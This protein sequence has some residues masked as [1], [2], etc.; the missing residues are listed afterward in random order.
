LQ[1]FTLH[2][3]VYTLANSTSAALLG[4]VS[5][6]YVGS[7]AS[8]ASWSGIRNY[9]LTSPSTHTGISNLTPGNYVFGLMASAGN[10]NSIHQQI[11]GATGTGALAGVGYVIPGVNQQSTHTSQGPVFIG[12]GSTTVNAMPANVVRSELVGQGGGASSPLQPWMVLRS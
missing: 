5:E 8:S 9:V 7:T 11:F 6:T 12:R 10:A 3:G 2:F 1:S 4:S